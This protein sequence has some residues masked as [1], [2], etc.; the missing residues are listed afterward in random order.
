MPN[1]YIY[2]CFYA[3]VKQISTNE[4]PVT[5]QVRE[6]DIEGPADQV[7]KLYKTIVEG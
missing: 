6:L 7:I 3:F 5:L 1:Q 2:C 4:K